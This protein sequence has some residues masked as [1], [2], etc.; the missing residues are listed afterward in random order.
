MD[1][2]LSSERELE[3]LD[4]ATAVESVDSEPTVEEDE[5]DPVSSEDRTLPFPRAWI[6]SETEEPPWDSI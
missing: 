3:E 6:A 4:E 2:L 1:E 5:E